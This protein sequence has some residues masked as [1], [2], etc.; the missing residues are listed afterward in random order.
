MRASDSEA[1]RG[2]IL[3]SGETIE[4]T[5][6]T[7]P[8]LIAER[9]Q[10]TKSDDEC[11]MLL[12]E[13]TQ[14]YT[15][16]APPR[17]SEQ[18]WIELATGI[19]DLEARAT[20]LMA[21]GGR[22]EKCKA[23]T[24]ARNVYLEAIC[25]E[26]TDRKMWYFAHNNL[27]YCLNQQGRFEE[28]ESYCRKAITIDC[29]RGN[30]YKNTGLALQGQ[31]RFVEAAEL[32]IAGTRECP[33]DERSLDHLVELLEAHPEIKTLIPTIDVDIWRCREL[34]EYRMGCESA[35]TTP[36]R[37]PFAFTLENIQNLLPCE[38]ATVIDD[39]N[40]LVETTLGGKLPTFRIRV[41]RSPKYAPDS[42]KTQIEFERELGQPEGW[43]AGLPKEKQD[44]LFARYSLR[45]H[46]SFASSNEDAV[47]WL[48]G[49]QPRV[50][51]VSSGQSTARAIAGTDTFHHEYFHV[52]MEMLRRSGAMPDDY[53]HEMTGRFPA[54]SARMELFNEEDAAEA[55]AE[56]VM[57]SPPG[58]NSEPWRFGI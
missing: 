33:E 46:T 22:L 37:P 52:M 7:Y 42:E 11:M 6:V 18:N 50:G 35:F 19:K 17:A 15:E 30:A 26:P 13:L 23:W 31:G 5:V 29:K 57:K 55:Y 39:D 51:G 28:G 24:D 49:L 20:A 4:G 40:I 43:F 53:V 21:M 45:G 9:I 44:E 8:R 34:V 12:N 1:T 3:P 48:A 10:I 14:F 54:R 16:Y 41:T 27:G 36:T 25:I 47:I 2:I 32:F 58:S 38:L 56:H